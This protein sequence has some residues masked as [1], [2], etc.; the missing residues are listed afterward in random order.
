[1]EVR[2]CQRGLRVDSSE[3]TLPSQEKSTSGSHSSVLSTLR[4]EEL[5]RWSHWRSF[6]DSSTTGECVEGILL[7]DKGR[8]HPDFCEPVV[9]GTWS[10]SLIDVIWHG[11]R[12]LK[13]Y[14][15]SC[16]DCLR[17]LPTMDDSLCLVMEWGVCT[18][19]Y[20]TIRWLYLPCSQPTRGSFPTRIFGL[21]TIS[22]QWGSVV[23]SWSLV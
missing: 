19:V 11:G 10:W 15:T 22:G 12:L 17:E 9:H 21:S 5:S 14:W 2:W 13:N 7:V 1:M 3:P 23:R 16:V 6:W 18:R 20:M 4:V 8:R